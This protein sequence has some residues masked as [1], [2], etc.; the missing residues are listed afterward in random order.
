MFGIR[1]YNYDPD[2]QSFLS[3]LNGKIPEVVY[4][5]NK[6]MVNRLQ[7]VLTKADKDNHG[8]RV[9]NTLERA[10]FCD[11]VEA[12]FKLKTEEEKKALRR[13]LANDQ[14]LPDIRYRELFESVDGISGKYHETLREQFIQEV[15]ASFE[16]VESSIRKA[17][18]EDAVA[19]QSI[20]QM[21]PEQCYSYLGLIKG[22]WLFENAKMT[23][24]QMLAIIGKMEIVELH[25]GDVIVYEGTWTMPVWF[26]YTCQ[27]SIDLSLSLSCRC[28]LYI[29][30]GD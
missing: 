27:R 2:C 7:E 30:A 10:E 17:A 24:E 28:A 11:T 15:Q 19:R 23:D 6:K 3:I 13:A 5:A 18:M 1:R 4:Y 16:N 29:H 25:E 14:P 20:R 26:V 12:Q 9:W 21:R 8:G 22:V